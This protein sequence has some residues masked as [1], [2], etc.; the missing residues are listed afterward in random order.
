[1]CFSNDELAWMRVGVGVL[2]VAIGFLLMKISEGK[3]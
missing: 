1:M 2:L 3:R